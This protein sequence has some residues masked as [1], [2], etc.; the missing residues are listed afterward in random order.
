MASKHFLIVAMLAALA[1]P[2]SLRAETQ[3]FGA[4]RSSNTSIVY[5]TV[6]DDW[7]FSALKVDSDRADALD[8]MTSASAVVFRVDTSTPKITVGADLIPSADSTYDL[9]SNAVRYTN[10][11]ADTVTATTF[12]GSVTMAIGGAISGGTATR[13]LYEDGSN[14]I[15]QDAGFTFDGT[16]LFVTG[17]KIADSADSSK[18]ATWDVS[19]ISGSTNRTITMPDQDVDLTPTSG[20]FQASDA[21]LTDIAALAVTDGN[22]IVGDGANWVAESGATARASLGLVIGTDVQAY[23]AEL[24]ALA[25]LTS[26]ADKL[27]YFTGS[28]AANVTALTA[29]GRSILDDADAATV[30]STIGLGSIA[31]QDANSVSITGGTLSGITSFT[32]E[33]KQ[34]IDDTDPEALLV[35]KDGDA[36]D[37][38][39]VDTTNSDIKITG[40][41]TANTNEFILDSSGNVGIG[42]TPEAWNTSYS[43]IQWGGIGSL[44]AP[45][46]PAGGDSV[47]LSSNAYYDATP[48]WKY[49]RGSG[50]VGD[51]AANYK[52]A[53]GT[54]VFR[55][56]SAGTADG[57][58]TWTTAMTIANDGDVTGGTAG[59]WALQN[60]VAS[61]T[62]PTIC[63]D[64]AGTATGLGADGNTGLY[65]IVNGSSI[66]ETTSSAITLKKNVRCTGANGY[67]AI[68]NELVSATNPL[69]AIF[70]NTGTGIGGAYNA[71]EANAY[72]SGIVDS[73]EIWRAAKTQFDIKVNAVGGT[74]G[75]WAL[76]NEAASATNPTLIP[77]RDAVGA[78]IGSQYPGSIDIIAGP[79][80]Q[81]MQF[82]IN[83][84]SAG[85]PLTK[86]FS[87]TFTDG[88]TAASG[89]HTGWSN[90]F[91]G[92][93]TLAAANS[94]VTTTNAA[95]LKVG[96]A[97]AAGTNMT[98]TNP[99]SLWVVD[100]ARFDDNLSV[101]GSLA[102]WSATY[103]VIQLG[104]V[105][106]FRAEHTAA[107]GN[108]TYVTTN[109]Y[110]DA[111]DSRWEY[112]VADEATAYRQR[113]GTH[114]FLYAAAGSADGAISWT[115]ALLIAADGAQT[116]R[117]HIKPG[118]D[119]TYDFGEQTTAQWANVWADLVNGAEVSLENKWRMME[120]DLFDGYSEGFALGHSDRWETGK[121]IYHA[122]PADKQ[123]YMAGL[124]PVFAVTDEFM[125]FQ[126]RR[127]TPRMLDV[128]V[129]LARENDHILSN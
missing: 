22:F 38:L 113:N 94:S 43:T 6:A 106:A 34:I 119:G 29:F 44:T 79:G 74:A 71:T 11:Y 64:N 23:D 52:Q 108:Y 58:I 61:R 123:R 68:M 70:G 109:A 101:G 72:V 115:S 83:Y 77:D 118:A 87:R 124:R 111:T 51:E 41:I 67:A 100:N 73:T 116:V 80:E 54:H 10:V 105:S 60:E 16:T 95:T 28:G 129:R 126:G 110:F 2:R 78:G 97:P 63:P 20:T 76:Q 86:L 37:V 13:V 30:R 89:T 53:N 117:G 49:I 4:I 98:I 88:S 59:S 31:T 82:Y 12:T 103:D 93:P 85:T 112:M 84:S 14:Q 81:A 42:V 36:G 33:G 102:N 3:I 1:F 57:A 32:L 25:G 99:W 45:T 114:E 48:G 128:L 21:G 125:E 122:A 47:L 62:N 55:V 19:A 107:A 8:I 24:A 75:S 69:F 65:I 90:F 96:S 46:T 40:T 35:R 5:D 7:D 120:A 104:G 27:P 9:G 56:A 91:I 17:L 26:A 66:I 39:A 92:Q 50:A 121:S 15:A 18:T 127:L